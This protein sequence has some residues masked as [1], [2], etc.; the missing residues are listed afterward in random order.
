M[1]TEK[2]IK[3]SI[4]FC[5][6]SVVSAIV[7]IAV[8]PLVSNVYP[9][10]EYG[11]INLF[12]SV[13]NMLLY[14]CLLGLDSAYIRFY[15]ER[16]D[17]VKKEQLFSLAMWTGV[18]TITVLT[19]LVIAFVP[20]LVSEY[21]FGELNYI[22]IIGML[23]YVVGL[24]VLRLISI[25]AR[26]D[27]RS[28]RYNIIQILLIL[29]GRVSFIVVAIYSTFY[30]YSILAISCTTFVL[31]VAF[32]I[33]FNKIKA[34]T[35]P[36]LK[37]KSL[38]MVFLFALPLM[39]ATIMIWLNNS[40]GKMI[41]SGYGNYDDVGILSIAT[42][43][44]NVFSVIPAAFT[45]YWSPFMYKN[46]KKEHVFIKNAHD[47]VC[48]LI[49]VL[50]AC[51][52][53]F[54][55]IIYIFVGVDYKSSQSYIMLVMLLPIQSLFCETTGYGISLSKK[56][57]YSL[58]VSVT[59]VATNFVLGVLLYR[60]IGVYGVTIGIA[61]SAVIMMIL[62]SVIGQHFYCSINDKRKSVVTM[63]IV[64]AVSV[65]NTFVYNDLSIR[66]II[67]LM[68]LGISGVIFHV[69]VKRCISSFVKVIKRI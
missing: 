11:K 18:G 31:G 8:I 21:M 10:D 17:D 36:K 22:C 26:M 5:V 58:L 20:D 51:F 65:A 6:P 32:C 27:A 59:A 23:L 33:G 66:I 29:T 55:D 42:S 28:L 39:P 45:V 9:T 38:R 60:I 30:Q 16:P 34:L 3:N 12:Y 63:A 56:T 44:S 4:K 25:E 41:L 68:V 1:E 52:F 61:A 15:F 24:V 7:A 37:K 69:Q 53:L 54:Q 48:L 50:V 57:Q 43:V 40:L 2:F 67:G 19:V 35:F 49:A 46:H 64:V 14:V 47:Y 13:G 62:T